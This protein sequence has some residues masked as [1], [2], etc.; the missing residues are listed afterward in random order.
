[1]RFVE[2]SMIAEQGLL[3]SQFYSAS[4]E[5]RVWM[6]ATSKTK[7]IMESWSVKQAE[8]RSKRK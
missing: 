6:L 3:P 5:D 2:M 8:M 7:A 1:M 4:Y